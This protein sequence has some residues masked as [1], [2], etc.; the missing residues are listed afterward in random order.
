MDDALR[1]LSRLAQAAQ[2]IETGCLVAFRDA[3]T[4]GA[5]DGSS[6]PPN[7]NS[8]ADPI[9]DQSVHF[10][11]ELRNF[12]WDTFENYFVLTLSSE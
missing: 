10:C 8:R 11:S 6:S 2:S 3:L 12:E 9:P 7:P 5:V 4:I 1:N